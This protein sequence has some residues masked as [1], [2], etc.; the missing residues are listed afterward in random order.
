MLVG[1]LALWFLDTRAGLLRAHGSPLLALVIDVG[2]VAGVV[3]VIAI[4]RTRG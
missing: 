4:G 3:L 1:V 2:A